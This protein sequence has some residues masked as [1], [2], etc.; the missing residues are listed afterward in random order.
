MFYEG[1]RDYG[2]D[3][4]KQNTL[5]SDFWSLILSIYNMNPEW[6]ILALLLFNLIWKPRIWKNQLIL[7]KET[8]NVE[9]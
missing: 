1:L 9:F 2:F 5:F 4:D 7:S 6:A 3:K 8:E